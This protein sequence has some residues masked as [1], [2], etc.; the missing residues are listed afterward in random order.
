MPCNHPGS[1]AAHTQAYQLL[2]D[3]ECLG[4]QAFAGQQYPEAVKHYTEALARGPS[5]VNSD[6]HK[7]YSNRAACYTKLGAWN[8]GLKVCTALS[9]PADAV[10]MSRGQ[11]AGSL[12][13]ACG[14]W[15]SRNPLPA[16]TVSI[17]CNLEGEPSS[18]HHSCQH[19]H[20]V[21]DWERSRATSQP[22]TGACVRQDADECIRLAPTFAKGYSRKGHLQFFMK[23][24][25]KAMATYELGLQQDPNN[26]ELK[27]GLSRCMHAIDRV[28][29]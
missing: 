20:H 28:R 17:L 13:Y 26:A 8:E 21:A 18:K 29:P 25:T 10:T 11:S 2:T 1:T 12:L 24:H 27:E 19:G 15:L 7:L 9:D 16:G 5:S 6:A 22:D 4:G 23:E 3:P 14:S